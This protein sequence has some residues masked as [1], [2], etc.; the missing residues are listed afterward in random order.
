MPP[1][2]GFVSKWYLVN[3]A[4][5]GDQIILLCMLLLSTL[6]NAAYFVPIFYRAFFMPPDPDA[7]IEQYSEAPRSMVIPLCATCAI[8]VLLGFYPQ[9]FL[10]FVQAFGRF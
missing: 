9:I 8:S 10:N 2:C 1:V 3:G 4:L 7:H 6:L 5:Q